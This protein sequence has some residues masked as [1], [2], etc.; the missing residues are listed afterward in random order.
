MN[1]I[2]IVT[3]FLV[4]AVTHY[5]VT[6]P[7]FNIRRTLYSYMM[8]DS[9]AGKKKGDG[10]SKMLG[11][12]KPDM[13]L[14]KK[15]D[16]AQRLLNTPISQLRA[17]DEKLQAKDDQIM[18]R[19]VAAQRIHNSAYA[20]M[21]AGELVQIR[22]M[23]GM[24]SN[25][26]LT[27]EQI[28]IRLNTI[29]ELGDIVVTLSPCMSVIRDLGPTIS[30]MMPEAATSMQDLTGI[31]GDLMSSSR[32]SSDSAITPQAVR[33]DEAESILSEANSFIETEAKAVIPEIPKSL[34]TDTKAPKET[35]IPEI[36]KSLTR[37]KVEQSVRSPIGILN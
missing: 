21:Y 31:M 11:K 24:V 14:S 28:Q 34:G 20:S 9:W 37:R 10:L 6:H 7:L 23:K 35:V 15:V 19:I 16:E 29:S 1:I 8:G 26:R 2:Y 13:P 3:V 4:T 18:R 30:G 32:M 33:S 25:A 27:M 22:K 17:I 5:M 36:P 12:A